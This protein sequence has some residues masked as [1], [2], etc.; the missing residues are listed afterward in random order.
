MYH[1]DA[2]G[3]ANLDLGTV[4]TRA[5]KITNLT[6]LRTMPPSLQ[7]YP[8]LTFTNIDHGATLNVLFYITNNNEASG[9]ECSAQ[10]FTLGAWRPVTVS[11]EAGRSGTHRKI[12][13]FQIE[14]AEVSHGKAFC[15][16]SIP[17]SIQAG[18]I[19]GILYGRRSSLLHEIKAD[20]QIQIEVLNGKEMGDLFVPGPSEAG[21][22]VQLGYPLISFYQGKSICMHSVHCEKCNMTLI[23]KKS[24]AYIY[25]EYCIKCKWSACSNSNYYTL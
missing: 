3:F 4:S 14:T 9:M 13:Q 5:L 22:D 18:D 19:L 6:T 10:D 12:A 15:S 11:S 23:I 2:A 24:Y 16:H 7:L 20:P 1:A 21:G 25:N 17:D 8:Q